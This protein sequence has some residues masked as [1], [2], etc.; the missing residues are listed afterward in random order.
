M[1]KSIKILPKCRNIAKSDHTDDLP[2]KIRNY[3]LSQ[4]YSEVLY[5][6]KQFACMWSTW[7]AR[8]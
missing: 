7:V 4:F 3:L 1:P 6:Q 2:Q 8:P 5:E